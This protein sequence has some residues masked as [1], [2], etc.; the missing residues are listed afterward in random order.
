MLQGKFWWDMTASAF[1]KKYEDWLFEEVEAGEGISRVKR[2]PG[3]EN[4]DEL[5]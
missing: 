1:E 5:T 2:E 4:S 3:T